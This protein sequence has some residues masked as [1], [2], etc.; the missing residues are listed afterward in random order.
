MNTERKIAVVTDS[1]ASI[2][3]ENGKAQELGVTVVPLEIK[4][5]ENGQY[6]P[7]KDSDIS[8]EEFYL[9]MKNSEKLPQTSGAAAGRFSETF[10]KLSKEENSIISVQI[11][12]KHSVAWESAILAKNIAEEESKEKM[13]IEV[14]DS[15]QVSLATWFLAEKA[16]QLAQKGASF[17]QVKNEVLETVPKVQLYTVLQGFENL[18]RGGRANEFIQGTLASLLSI[19]P[20]MGFSDGKLRQYGRERTSNKARQRMVE[21]VNDSGPLVKLAVVHTNAPDLAQQVKDLLELNYRGE[22]SI[23]EAGPVLAVHAGEGAVGVAFQK[24]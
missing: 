24:A 22:I 4:F 20:I 1:G 15:K 8:S 18:K 16:A 19:Y 3:P 7:Y 2:R 23:Y 10:N 17:E 9:R 13:F 5:F 6:V 21:M 12:S 14:I 11:T